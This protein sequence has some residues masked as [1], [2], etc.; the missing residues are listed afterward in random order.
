MQVL[1]RRLAS[2][3]EESGREGGSCR[4]FKVVDTD[5]LLDSGACEMIAFGKWKVEC[6]TATRDEVDDDDPDRFG[7]GSNAEACALAFDGMENMKRAYVGNSAHIHLQ[8]IHTDPRH[9]RRGA[10]LLLVK[11][12]K[13]DGDAMGLSVW[14]ES[15]D[16]GHRL[17][18]R[19][20]FE[21]VEELVTD[22]STWGAHHP[23]RSWLMVKH[24]RPASLDTANK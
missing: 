2:E 14:L 24:A 22:L 7:P 11:R 3:I 17:Y 8:T 16:D 13:Q 15:S 10:G 1:A 5:V 19:C 12:C 21:D 20:G 9:Q 6:A 18:Q 23:H 4:A